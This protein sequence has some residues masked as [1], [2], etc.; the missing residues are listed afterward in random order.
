M[1]G[2]YDMSLNIFFFFSFA[3]PFVPHVHTHVFPSPIAD[4]RLGASSRSMT[5]E[6]KYQLS[7]HR[8]MQ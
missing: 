2:P 5:T 4:S 1:K 7:G 3:L 8:H 6:S